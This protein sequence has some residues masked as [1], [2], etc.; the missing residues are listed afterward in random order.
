MGSI[1]LDGPA[2]F[3][4][5]D[6]KK[7][8]GGKKILFVGDSNMRAWYKD[9]LVIVT[10][11]QVAHPTHFKCK[12][13][14]SFYNDS[15]VIADDVKGR[16][17]KEVRNYTQDGL[18]IT[19]AFITKCWPNYYL[20]SKMKEWRSGEN[21]PDF[22]V[23]CSVAWDISRYG[24]NGV[25]MFKRSLNQLIYEVKSC[26]APGSFLWLTNPPMGRKVTAAFLVEDLNFLAEMM[27]Y[28][29][30]EANAYSLDL[31]IKEEI[32]VFDL[33]YYMCYVT[34]LRDQDATHWRPAGVRL[35]VCLLLTHVCALWGIKPP[36]FRKK[37]VE[38]M[39]QANYDTLMESFLYMKQYNGKLPQWF[40]RT[41][42]FSKRV[43]SI[44]AV[45]EAQPELRDHLQLF[46]KPEEE[47]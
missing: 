17:Y 16:D 5:S 1:D 13:E 37:E 45:L 39:R 6:V 10:R 44:F 19:F 8:F 9:L 25:E 22:V 12:M 29:V 40:E 43:S 34:D 41:A 24:V 28:H 7:L 4:D 33:H 42:E 31:M 18:D 11:N 27:R 23:M 20:S 26:L 38:T 47:A 15:L 3:L 35:I 36:P 21:R 32:D 14:E 30:M 2:L 46:Q